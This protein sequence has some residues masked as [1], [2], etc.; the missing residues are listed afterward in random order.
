MKESKIEAIAKQYKVLVKKLSDE[1]LRDILSILLCDPKIAMETIDNGQKLEISKLDDKERESHLHN[2]MKLKTFDQPRHQN[3]NNILE[4]DFKIYQ[5]QSNPSLVIEEYNVVDDQPDFDKTLKATA[6][7]KVP[8]LIET[9]QSAINL[10]LTGQ[11]IPDDR[12]I[13]QIECF[14]SDHSENDYSVVI[15]ED[16]LHPIRMSKKIKIWSM[17]FDL[18]QNGSIDRNEA[19]QDLYDYINYNSLNKISTNTKYQLRGIIKQ[20]DSS[21]EPR[22]KTSVQTEKALVQR[23]NKLKSST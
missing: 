2:A 10:R 23:Q 6:F 9:I 3:L 1:D 11:E 7:P 15:N 18:I 22:F 16:Y 12:V 4:N 21:Y 17:F 8:L 13:K 19:T 5:K 20:N 14:T